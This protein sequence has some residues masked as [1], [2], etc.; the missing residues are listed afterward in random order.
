MKTKNSLTNLEKFKALLIAILLLLASSTSFGQNTTF[1]V[2]A[3][4]NNTTGIANSAF[5]YYTMFTNTVGSYN[6]ASGHQALYNNLDGAFNTAYGY[7]ALYRSNSKYNTAVGANSLLSTT[8]GDSNTGVGYSSMRN[9]TTGRGNTAVGSET[10]Y[11][12]QTGV[13][14]T[15][16]G[17]SALLGNADGSRNTA[18]GYLSLRANTSGNDNTAAGVNA[19]FNNTTGSS[20]TSAGANSLYSNTT[21]INNSAFGFNALYSNTT[22]G[23]NT[24]GGDNALYSSIT[25]YGNT[26][27]GYYSMYNSTSASYSVANGYYTLYRNTTGNYN[28][29]LGSFALYNNTTGYLNTAV[30]YAAGYSSPNNIFN[31]TSV[32]YLAFATA[33][34]S[35]RIGNTSVTSIGGQVGWTTFSD[36]RF[37]QNVKEDVPGIEFIK[38]LRPVTYTVD[39]ESL[40]KQS[41]FFADNEM[42]DENA[43]A[44]WKKQQAE[45]AKIIHTGFIAQEVEEA[46]KSLKYNFSGVVTP[47]SEKDHYSIRY[48]EF[49]V[50][51]VKAAQQQQEELESLKSNMDELRK[52]NAELKQLVMNL[53]GNKTS[54]I[55]NLDNNSPVRCF[56]NP[57]DGSIKVEIDNP[58]QTTIRTFVYNMSGKLLYSNNS[59]DAKLS[60]DVDLSGQ[61]NGTYIIQTRVGEKSFQNKV[62]LQK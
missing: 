53:L 54:N 58:E 28:T 52:E 34:N 32:G 36:G 29:S 9:N 25:G 39:Y 44:T 8:N 59:T 50:P 27:N 17:M 57:S 38:Q 11:N 46:A 35:V 31:A 21:G 10:M 23:Y 60:L 4:L 45:N 19:L 33:S 14:N 12:N 49:V 24:V 18:S 2:G 56:P 37:K 26:V 48:A 40:D 15:A 1:G 61:P 5:G 30:G 42:M 55:E 13:S 22:G 16:I 62:I 3:L 20:N 41:G 7:L 6:T 43:R 51:L 47:E